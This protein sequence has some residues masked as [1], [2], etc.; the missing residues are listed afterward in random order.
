MPLTVSR[1]GADWLVAESAAGILT[2]EKLNDEHRLVGQTAMEFVEQEVAPALE[3]LEKKNWELS[4]TLLRRSGELGLVGTD[5]P[6]SVG[7][8]GL[9]KAASVD[10][11]RGDWRVAGVRH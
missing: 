5:V 7:G 9:D 1:P 8:V 2:P 6:E 11:W 10:R 3:E 4:R